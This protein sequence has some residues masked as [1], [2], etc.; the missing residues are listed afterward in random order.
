ML[1]A[2]K[3]LFVGIF[4]FMSYEVVTTQIKTPLFE[5]WDFLANV[6]WMKTTLLDFYAN[7]LVLSAWV[8]YKESKLW[9]KCMWILLFCTLGSIATAAYVLLQLFTAKKDENSLKAIFAR[10]NP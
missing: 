3:I 8:C 5:N 2:L 7:V 1:N 6:P 10:Q 9:K 4:L